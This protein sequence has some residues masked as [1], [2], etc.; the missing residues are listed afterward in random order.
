[1]MRTKWKIT[2]TINL[3]TNI[4]TRSLGI[5]PYIELEPINYFLAIEQ[6]NGITMERIKQIAE[7]LC[8]E[9]E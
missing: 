4:H 5:R 8:N 6:R 1:M 9:E 2:E 7:E 3:K